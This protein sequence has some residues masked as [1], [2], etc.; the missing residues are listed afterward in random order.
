MSL[1]LSFVCME[2]LCQPYLCDFGVKVLIFFSWQGNLGAN[3]ILAVSM[4]ACKA[5]AAEKGV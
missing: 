4:A 1:V 2:G 5:G 3:A